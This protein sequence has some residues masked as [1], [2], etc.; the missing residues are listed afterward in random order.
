MPNCFR[1]RGHSRSI[2]RTYDD[3]VSD[4]LRAPI[5]GWDFSGL[6][7]RVDCDD[8]PWDYESLARE[9]LANA[10]RLLDIDTGGGE[11]LASLAPLPAAIA[12]EPHPPNLPIATRRLAPLGVDVRAGRASALP[13]ADEDVDLV[14]NRH[15]SLDATETARVLTP[16]GVF[17]TQ[18][19]GSR[20]D[21]AFNDALGVPPPSPSDAQTLHSTVAGLEDAGLVIDQALEDYPVTRYFDVGAV[22]FQLRSVPWQVPGFDVGTSEERL[23]HLD[24][25]IRRTGSFDVKSHRFLVRAHKC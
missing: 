24:V 5:K 21:L 14:L 3:L 18:Q 10:T 6:T 4:A 13:V 1:D 11:A 2:G 20:N 7:G 25:Y 16:Q 22:V 9:A 17:L 23:R 12:T 8:L 15:G 19:V